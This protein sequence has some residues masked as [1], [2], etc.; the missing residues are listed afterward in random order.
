MSDPVL[1]V[2][3]GLAGVA[4]A[5]VLAD[6]GLPVRVVDRGRRLGG[7]MASRRVDGRPVDLGASYLTVSDPGFAAVV[8]DWRRRGLARE[9]TDTF[10]VTGADPKRGAMRWGAAG[11]LRSLVEDLA[12]GLDVVP[13]TT[14]R[15]V[16]R[17]A[18]GLSVDGLGTPAV[19]LAMPDPQAYRLLDSGL[20]AGLPAPAPFEPILALVARWPE[21][22]WGFDGMFVNDHPVLSWVADDGARRGDGA[23]V[24]VAHSTPEVAAR[25]LDDPEAAEPELV[26]ALVEVAG[27]ER[28]PL[29]TLVH[30]WT[31]AR[32]AGPR[33]EPFL[34]DRRLGLC[35]D[36]WSQKPRVEAAYLSGYALGV[37]VRDDLA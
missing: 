16:A 20:R 32:P 14:V 4:C 37:A 1:V 19:V 29:G 35:G 30:R 2:G 23:P 25:Y 22:R 8:E 28:R 33:T 24:L 15:R 18:D 5:R 10:A 17:G 34:L 6:A 3:A 36:G 31:H 7:R 13:A 11:G 26:A 21:R 9:W 27:L 12:A